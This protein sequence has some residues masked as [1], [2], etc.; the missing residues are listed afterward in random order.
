M[1]GETH[2]TIMLYGET[3]KILFAIYQKLLDSWPFYVYFGPVVFSQNPRSLSAYFMFCSSGIHK[4]R[5]VMTLVTF[6]EY[7][8]F[9]RAHKIGI[10]IQRIA[11][12]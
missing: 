7:T 4:I 11:G 5:V 1:H 3:N 6:P 8:T 2:K 10:W 12:V 9:F